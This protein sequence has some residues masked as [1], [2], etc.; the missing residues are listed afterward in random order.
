MSAKNPRNLLG[1]IT[2]KSDIKNKWADTIKLY[3]AEITTA[4]TYYVQVAFDPSLTAAGVLEAGRNDNITV[5]DVTGLSGA[6]N[7]TVKRKPYTQD[8]DAGLN[9]LT[10]TPTITKAGT[11]IW[12]LTKL[13][14]TGNGPAMQ[15]AESAAL[16]G[17]GVLAAA[18]ADNNDLMRRMGDLRNC[19][20]E[21]GFWLRYYG[22]EADV[23]A[24]SGSE[25]KYKY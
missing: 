18:R 6:N 15:M 23:K 9:T 19:N 5:V 20:D 22:G 14:A 3:G 25:L 12:N 21:A 4:Q 17:Q 24:G 13:E 2:A 10:L 16:A 8:V 7:V 11:G 1:G